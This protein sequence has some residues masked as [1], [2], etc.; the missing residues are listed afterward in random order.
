MH[1]RTLWTLPAAMVIVAK[2]RCNS[3]ALT[4]LD[5]PLSPVI[6]EEEEMEE[7]EEPE[8][9]VETLNAADPGPPRFSTAPQHS[10]E[11]PGTSRPLR[12]HGH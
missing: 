6:K 9:E 2:P 12:A 5:P 8:Q 3:S 1:L 4:P 7:E 10:L 11:C